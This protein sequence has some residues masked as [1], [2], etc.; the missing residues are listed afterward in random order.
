MV[1]DPNDMSLREEVWSIAIDQQAFGP[2]RLLVATADRAG[3]LLAIAHTIQTA[4]PE[5][6]LACCLDHL[7]SGA[8]AAVAF[9]DEPVTPG[10]PPPDLPERFAAA[11]E[12]AAAFEIHLVDWFTCDSES[13]LIRSMRLA[14]D[15]GSEW[16]DLP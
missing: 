8:A 4:P 12:T 3:R 6:A 1:K 15:P 16:W 10:P 13:E 5:L 2:C 7:G 11:R 9:S 14:L